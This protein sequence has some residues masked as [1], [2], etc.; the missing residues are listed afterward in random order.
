MNV[1]LEDADEP[2]ENGA[3]RPPLHVVENAGQE[4]AQEAL[5]SGGRGKADRALA[6]LRTM[7]IHRGPLGL[8]LLRDDMVVTTT[9]P[10]FVDAV[11]AE[12]GE[13]YPDETISIGTIKRALD[14]LRGARD[15][16]TTTRTPPTPP[17]DPGDKRPTLIATDTDLES[18]TDRTIEAIAE[19]RRLFQRAHELVHVTCAEGDEE[20]RAP[21]AKGSP[22][23]HTV[24]MPTMRERI[25]SAVRWVRVNAE[26]EERSALPPDTVVSAVLARG[27]WRGIDPI[28]G[29]TETPFLRPDG[30]LV[31]RAGYD[32]ATGYLYTPNA[33]YPVVPEAPTEE[34]AREA[35]ALLTDVWCDFPFVDDA[36]RMVPV[37]T[38]LT[39]LARPGIA[40]AVPGMG[41]DAST[42]GTGKT[43]AAELEVRIGTG[44]PPP[45][46]T[47][48]AGRDGEAELEKMLGAYALAGAPVVFFDNVPIGVP[49]GGAPLEKVLT[50]TDKV[51]LRRLGQSEAPEIPWRSVIIV[52]GNNLT[53]REENA[54]RMLVCRQVSTIER[55]EERTGFRH[56]KLREYV[57]ENRPR[58]VA[59]ALTILRGYVAAGRPDVGTISLGSFEA[60]S[61]LVPAAIRWAGGAD[62]MGARVTL[63]GDNDEAM[64]TLATVLGHLRSFMNGDS[65]GLTANAILDALYPADRKRDAEP[66]GWDELRRSIESATSTRPGNRPDTAAFGRYL[67]GH[68]DRIVDGRRLVVLG[69][70]ARA[71]RWGVT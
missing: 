1:H 49:F 21:L 25:A 9:T 63:T 24:T 38:T 29:V 4:A 23:I 56:P 47:F 64:A 59:A 28:V 46:A 37:A 48:P 18:L 6:V 68:R 69:T 50:A 20:S 17:V 53:I 30:S 2:A 71:N 14:S 41:H 67:R 10:A 12:W 8:V 36:S 42:R 61:A 3:E 43:F 31:Q 35:L 66:D 70:H 45:V 65:N 39:I 26:G 22:V 54:R 32:R 58:L 11:R 33:S 7:P 44:R 19:D 55:P 13:V 15:L 60:W 57:Q 40:G 51:S 5:P 27:H 52:S 34:Q 62:V 16:P